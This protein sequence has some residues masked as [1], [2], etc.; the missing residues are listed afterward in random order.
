[1]FSEPSQ[2]AC[3]VSIWCSGVGMFSDFTLQEADN[4]LDCRHP[5]AS[6]L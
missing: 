2:C 5:D 1:M 4:I 6:G 3:A